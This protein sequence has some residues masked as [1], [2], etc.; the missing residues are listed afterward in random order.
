MKKLVILSVFA[1]AI[2]SCSSFDLTNSSSNSIGGTTD[3]PINTVGNVF[4]T[5][6]KMGNN[7]YYNGTVSVVTKDVS[8]A[9]ISTISFKATLPSNQPLL[10][11]IKSK[12]LDSKGNLDCEGTFK[13][14]DKGILD[15]NNIDHKPFVLVKYDAKVGDKYTLKKSDGETITRTVVSK[16][17]TD[18]YSWGLWLIKTINVEQ[19]SRIPGVTKLEYI[20]NHKFGLVGVKLY[21]EDGTTS[22]LSL[23]ANYNNE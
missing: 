5:S 20:T 22:T 2:T 17:T 21:L 15:F 13:M 18:D 6:I 16:S 3:I 7:T 4:G 9:G 14:T 10:D 23:F 19:D 8:S 11:G 1:I 12:Y